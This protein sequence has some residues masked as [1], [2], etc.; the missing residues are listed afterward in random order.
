MR[1]TFTKPHWQPAPVLRATVLLHGLAAV[2]FAL[3]PAWWLWLLTTVAVNHMLIAFLSL[4][5]RSPWLGPNLTRLP[6]E[7]AVR[8]EVC[9]TI[10]D[11]PDPQVTPQVLA[12]LAASGVKATFFCIGQRALAYPDLCRRICAEGH[13]LENH[14]FRHSPY[15]PFSGPRGWQREIKMAQLALTQITGQAPRFYRAMAGLRNPFLDPVLQ[16]LNIRLVSW[17]K[18]G[19]DTRN[20]DAAIVL[21]H[22]THNLKAGDILLLHDGHCARTSSGQP[23]I[24]VVL[25]RLLN[26][27]AARGLTAVTL[28]QACGLS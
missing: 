20:H 9:V 28:P 27:L 10:D 13:T 24:L 17:T 23:V 6:P 3:H 16:A 4:W 15:L 26:E 5:P 11:G 25:P 2:L 22:L 21:A 12:L 14:G 19:F 7:A 1:L 8:S 18:R